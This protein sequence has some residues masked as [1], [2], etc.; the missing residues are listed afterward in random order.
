MVDLKFC[1]L[2]G[3]WHHVTVPAGRFTPTLL[4]E[5]V[6]FDGSSL[7]FKAVNAGDMVL[8]PDLAA[9]FVDPFWEV[10]TL[11]FV[12]TTLEADTRQLFPYDPRSIAQ[13]A[14]AFLRE[15]GIADESRWGPEYEFKSLRRRLVREP[16]ERRLYRVES[17][18]T[19]EQQWGAATHPG[20]AATTPSRRDRC[21]GA[22]ADRQ[23]PRRCV[24]A[25]TTTTRSAVLA[26][27]S[28]PDL[29]DA[30]GRGRRSSYAR[31]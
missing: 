28:R 3:R 22:D 15:S 9:G 14:E 5:G 16:D 7:G 10:P 1:D 25:G 29:P 26:M 27:R 11:S 4:E 2:W 24:E 6:G 30:Q 13:R 12:C 21:A 20:T 17:R 8:V 19:E 18:A 23:E 31:G